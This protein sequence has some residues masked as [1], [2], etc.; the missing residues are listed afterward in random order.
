MSAFNGSH[1]D[2]R[3]TNFDL[4]GGRLNSYAGRVTLAPSP[5]V[6]ASAWLAYLAPETGDHAHAGL[7]KFGMAVLHTRERPAGSWSSALI[8]G[9]NLTSGSS[10]PLQ[11][12]LLESSLDLTRSHTVFARLEY[13]RRTADELA[14]TGSVSS[15]LD[16]GAAS[17][18]YAWRLSA[19]RA[20]DLAA[21][22]RLTVTFLAA[23][24]EPFYG[25][26]H[27]VGF[28]VYL[29]LTPPTP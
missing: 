4:Q 15:E 20:A 3:R 11:T 17:L 14:L 13:A 2:D 18:G 24:L 9:A 6:T 28:L 25:T 22:T 16:V 26:Q 8:Y 21:G 29:R 23:E 10:R 5:R 19:T 1:P 27:P 7:H 12:A